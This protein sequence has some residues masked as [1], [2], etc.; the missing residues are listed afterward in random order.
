MDYKCM[1]SIMQE[2]LQSI[3]KS[4][5]YQQR[6]VEN[7][8]N[9]FQKLQQENSRLHSEHFKDEALKEA[10]ETIQLLRKQFDKSFSIT[11]EEYE[12]IENWKKQHEAEAHNGTSIIGAIGG[13]YTYSFT[14]TSIGTVGTIHCTCGAEFTFSEI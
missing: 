9:D 14:P 7:I 10:E 5:E 6:C 3:A 12:K 8:V 4:I 11:E 2:N 1:L 13:R